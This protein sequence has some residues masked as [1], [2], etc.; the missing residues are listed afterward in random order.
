MGFN[1]LWWALANGGSGGGGSISL[2]DKRIT[3]NGEYTADAGYDGLGTV[4]VDVAGS[5]AIEAGIVYDEVQTNGS[6]IRATVR[7]K[8]IAN[9]A[10]YTCTSLVSVTLPSELTRIGSN[11]FVSCQSLESLSLPKGLTYIDTYAFSNCT[12]L[13]L[14]S[15]PDGL[16]T[17]RDY[18]F[19][20]CKS[21]KTIDFPKTLQ[22]IFGYAFNRCEGLSSV[23]FKGIPMT[24]QNNVFASC[25]N[26]TTI[27]VPWAEG[28]VA[29]APW[30]ATNATI[31]Y[32]YTGA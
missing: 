1:P 28:A 3:E 13:V 7:G 11:A 5:G 20:L 30:G 2:Q 24:V 17:I 32:N 27:N 26:L 31:N 14:S 23:T 9:Y 15:F 8:Q 29:N 25:T 6:L 21:L 16:T 22:F 4:T 19:S 10:F 18:G 12:K